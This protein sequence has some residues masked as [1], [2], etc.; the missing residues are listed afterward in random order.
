[1]THRNSHLAESAE[2]KQYDQQKNYETDASAAIIP[3][4]PARALAIVETSASEN[5]KQDNNYQD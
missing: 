5:E 3:R 4:T 1:M 2:E